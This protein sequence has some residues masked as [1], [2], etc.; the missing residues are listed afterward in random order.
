MRKIHNRQHQKLR[1]DFKISSLSTCVMSTYQNQQRYR[2]ISTYLLSLV[3]RYCITHP[4]TKQT[5]E[6]TS[7]SH[8]YLF[9]VGI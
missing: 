3:Y 6:S 2:N 4:D 5:R 1:P 8:E 9:E 7:L